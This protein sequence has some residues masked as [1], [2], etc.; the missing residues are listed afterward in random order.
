MA[1]NKLKLSHKVKK[2]KVIPNNFG[3]ITINKM[4]LVLGETF[5]LQYLYGG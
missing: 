4:V 5:N 2:K 3:L 1:N